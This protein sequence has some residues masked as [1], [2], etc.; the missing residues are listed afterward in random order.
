MVVQTTGAKSWAVRYQHKG[1][2]RNH[3]LGPF[4]TIALSQA[5]R[6]AS[7]VRLRVAAGHDPAGDKKAARLAEEQRRKERVGPTFDV[8][9]ARHLSTLRPS[10]S[11]EI[12]R[13]FRRRVL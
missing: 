4:P 3:W 8:Y 2:G 11:K 13:L 5:R 12:D 7:E 10:T 1:R 9:K 6:L